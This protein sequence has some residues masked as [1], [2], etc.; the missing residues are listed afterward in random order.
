[1][2]PT[3]GLR[4]QQHPGIRAEGGL[5]CS[6]GAIAGAVIDDDD[7]RRWM[8]LVQ[9]RADSVDDVGFVVVAGHDYADGIV[10]SRGRHAGTG[11]CGQHRPNLPVSQEQV[12]MSVPDRHLDLGCGDSPRNPYGRTTLCGVDICPAAAGAAHEHRVP[13][14]WWAPSPTR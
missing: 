9:R 3:I 12:R 10:P 6:H 7:L 4:E 8:A 14:W 1:H 11:I 2:L 13:T 5:Q